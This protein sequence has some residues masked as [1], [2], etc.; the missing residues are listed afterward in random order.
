[1]T[2][3]RA[4]R[5][6]RREDPTDRGR[7]WGSEG[8]AGPAASLSGRS[9]GVGCGHR[10]TDSTTALSTCAGGGASAGCAAGA[11]A[12]GLWR[13]AHSVRRR[14]RLPRRAGT[15]CA[16]MG[17]SGRGWRAVQRRSGAPGIRGSVFW[18]RSSPYAGAAASGRTQRLIRTRSALAAPRSNWKRGCSPVRPTSK[19]RTNPR[20]APCSRWRTRTAARDRSASS[21]IRSRT[22][23]A[24]WSMTSACGHRPPGPT[25]L[26]GAGLPRAS[27][28]RRH[29]GGRRDREGRDVH[30][31]LRCRPGRWGC[32]VRFKIASGSGS[33]SGLFDD[34]G[35]RNF[36]QS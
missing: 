27:R 31:A 6:V 11:P 7:P 3:G 18:L 30:G 32:V 12:A 1:M 2:P 33:G 20:S 14:V 24:Q 36:S 22:W 15:D 8:T 26:E 19:L 35:L 5:M 10:E 16:G 34:L 4:Q 28:A 9:R 17:D 21:P 29:I 13:R 25:V 23:S